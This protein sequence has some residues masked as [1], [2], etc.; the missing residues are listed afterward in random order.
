MKWKKLGKIFDPTEY[1]D[2][3]VRDWMKEY[4]QCPSAVVYNDFVRI[5]FSSRP[6]RDANGQATSYTGFF[7][8]DIDDLHNI[9]R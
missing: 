1:N 8:V 3:I 2:G 7:D 9:I 4:A 6:E 5:Y